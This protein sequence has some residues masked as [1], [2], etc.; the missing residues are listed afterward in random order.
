[1]LECRMCGACCIALSI[2]T[3]IPGTDSGKP[4]GVRCIHL[5]NDNRCGIYESR[6][7]VCREFTRTVDLCGNNFEDT[8][9][10]LYALELATK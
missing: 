8:L 1:M 7:P 2:S 10:N 3:T 5:D 4:A 6:P 9:K